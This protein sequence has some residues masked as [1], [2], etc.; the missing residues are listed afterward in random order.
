MASVANGFNGGEHSINIRKRKFPN[1]SLQYGLKYIGV[2][3][4]LWAGIKKLIQLQHFCT[5]VSWVHAFT[6][7]SLLLFLLH[8]RRSWWTIIVIFMLS[9]ALF[10]LFVSYIMHQRRSLLTIVV[11]SC[12]LILFPLHQRRSLWTI[13]VETSSLVSWKIAIWTFPVSTHD[14]DNT[15]IDVSMYNI[16]C[17]WARAGSR[18]FGA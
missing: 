8:Q 9:Y 12:S 14:C 13:V 18:L 3:F 2:I 11:I 5:S 17:T 1:L 16:H 15:L 7:L 6:F 10:C 4:N